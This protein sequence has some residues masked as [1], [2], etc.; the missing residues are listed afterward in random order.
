MRKCEK[1]L[2]SEFISIV[3]IYSITQVSQQTFPRILKVIFLK[4][5]MFMLLYFF[6]EI[7]NKMFFFLYE[8]TLTIRVENA[9]T[10]VLSSNNII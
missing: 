7:L 2:P 10:H 9:C 4:F 8:N 5:I 6:A 1:Y 3:R